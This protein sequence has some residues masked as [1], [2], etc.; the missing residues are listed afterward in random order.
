LY[1]Q[2]LMTFMTFYTSTQYKINCLTQ[3][4]IYCL[5]FLVPDDFHAILHQYSV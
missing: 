5:V 1:F 2:F 3:Y 4:K